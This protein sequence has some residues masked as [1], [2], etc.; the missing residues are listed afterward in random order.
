MATLDRRKMLKKSRLEKVF[1]MFDKVSP[2][3]TFSLKIK[4][5]RIWADRRTGDKGGVW[6]QRRQHRSIK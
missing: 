6:D 1:N 4:T 3:P 5:G 2:F